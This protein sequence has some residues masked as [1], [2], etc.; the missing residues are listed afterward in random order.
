MSKLQAHPYN[1]I[2]MSGGGLKGFALLGAMQYMID[3]KLIGNIKYYSGT[4]IG[5]IISYFLAIGY[6]PI[7][8]IVYIITHNVFDK[9]DHKSIDS[10]LNGEG[11]YDF[12][13]YSSH[14]KKMSLDKIGYIPTFKDLY[15]KMNVTLFTCT[16]NITKKKKEYLSIYTYPDMSCI[17][18]I[19]LS[20]SLPFIFNDCIY[21]DEYFIDGGIVDNCPFFPIIEN[22]K[23]DLLHVVIFNLQTNLNNKYERLVD[24][25]VML[26]TIPIDELQSIQLKNITE[27]CLYINVKI[28]DI[29]FYD[30]HINHSEKLEIFSL[31]YNCAKNILT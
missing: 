20:S 8:M 18:A 16:Y 3:N 11:I 9:K 13:I 5:A 25:I 27:N 6:T 22:V 4:S 21:K 19:T 23:D 29:S 1:A 31:G 26:L 12:S 28:R 24:K 30:F 10:I 14:F 15:E 17:D 7:E 2:V